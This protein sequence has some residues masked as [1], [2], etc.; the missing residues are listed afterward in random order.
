V[1]YR[2][3]DQLGDLVDQPINAVLATRRTDGT[4][5]LSPVWFMWRDGGFD[6]GIPAGDRKLEHL[7]RDPQVSILIFENGGVGRGLEV[8]GHAV[9]E[10]DPGRALGRELSIK[11]LGEEEGLR[12]F[13]TIATSGWRVRIEGRIRAWDYA[14]LEY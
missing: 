11:Y 3:V 2:T 14:D 13:E 1:T 7:A 8:T 12:Y 5:L 6:V 4:T 10:P 9:V